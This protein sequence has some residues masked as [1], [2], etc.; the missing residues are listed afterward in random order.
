MAQISL[1]QFNHDFTPS[2]GD[3]LEF[4]YAIASYMRTLDKDYLPQGV[5]LVETRHSDDP[6]IIQ[7][8]RTLLLEVS[9]YV[10]SCCDDVTDPA[11]QLVDKIDALLSK[12]LNQ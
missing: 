10:A 3:H 7:K 11:G 4:G 6:S 8:M 12:G 9:R 2:S 1:L 5:A